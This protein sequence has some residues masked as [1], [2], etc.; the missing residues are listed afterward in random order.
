M[1]PF[2]VG[3]LVELSDLGKKS[4]RDSRVNPHLLVGR[5][6]LSTE[7][8]I[9]YLVHWANGAE[10]RYYRSEL[11]ARV[12]VEDF[13]TTYNVVCFDREDNFL[14]GA[15][16]LPLEEVMHHVR[17]FQAEPNIP[18]IVLFKGKSE[19]VRAWW[20]IGFNLWLKAKRQEARPELANWHKRVLE[21]I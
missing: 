1:E 14:K 9:P 12:K 21:I 2:K 7:V 10:N 18:Y 8:P 11:Q 19:Q 4:L 17:R 20:R 15:P 3:E 13:G 5:V 6:V 16:N